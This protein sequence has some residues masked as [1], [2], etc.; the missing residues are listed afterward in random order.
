ME[1]SLAMANCQCEDFSFEI[2]S[3]N[4]LHPFWAFNSTVI[5]DG[6]LNFAEQIW[7]NLYAGRNEALVTGVLSFV[8]HELVYFGR[9]IPF[10]IADYIPSFKKYKLQQ[11]KPNTP[12]IQWKCFKGVLFGHFFVE[13]PLISLFH[14]TATLFGMQITQ[15]PFPHWQTMAM[16]IAFFFVFEDTFH[17]WF[18]RLLH[19]GPFYKHIH[20]QHHE[21]AAPFG[22]CAEYAHPVEVLILGTGTIGGPL[23]WVMATGNL[24]IITV[25]IWITLRLLQAIDAHSGYDFPWS[26]R[27]F[28][29]FWSGAEHHDYHHMAFV[30]NYSTSFRWWDAMMGTDK[31][32]RA[33]RSRQKKE[34]EAQDTKK[35]N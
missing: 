14:P 34:R 19:Y 12:E 9:C 28:L 15:V 3:G 27:H 13:L 20:K 35:S 17:Y 33:Y 25:Y 24:H 31:K 23:L 5:P 22:L 11:D 6:N 2:S 8:L 4:P 30:N 10:M 18:H 26:L 1:P 32:Y 21:Y 29:P 7:S 16:Q